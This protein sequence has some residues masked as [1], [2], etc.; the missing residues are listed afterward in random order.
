MIP[1]D[2]GNTFHGG[3]FATGGNDSMQADNLTPGPQALGFKIQN[4]VQSVYD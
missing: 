4:R 3:M 1:H 2:G